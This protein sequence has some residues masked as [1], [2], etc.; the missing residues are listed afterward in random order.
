LSLQLHPALKKTLIIICLGVLWCSALFSQDNLG[1]AGS[2][3][4]PVNTVLNNPSTIV[5]SR[6]FIDINLAGISVFAIL[7][8][9]VFLP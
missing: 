9:S 3:R 7:Q 4:A 8:A 2:T 6:A 5:D 1:I